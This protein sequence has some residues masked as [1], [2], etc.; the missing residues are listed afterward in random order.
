MMASGC[1]AEFPPALSRLADA[2]AVA[3]LVVRLQIARI[4][5]EPDISSRLMGYDRNAALRLWL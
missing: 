4:G 2:V 5:A 3:T 1:R